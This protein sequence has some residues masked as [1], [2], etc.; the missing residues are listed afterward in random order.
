MSPVRLWFGFGLALLGAGCFADAPADDTADLPRR[1]GL[2]PDLGVVVDATYH[3]PALDD[4][5]PP[6]A[7]AVDDADLVVVGERV[8]LTFTL[9]AG[10]GGQPVAMRFEGRRAT[11][12]GAFVVAGAHGVG[13]C[14]GERTLACELEYFDDTPRGVLRLSLE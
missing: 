12:G 10:R 1:A 13:S 8:E 6:A 2:A 5:A 4:L 14:R 3:V 9:P 7:Y 11:A